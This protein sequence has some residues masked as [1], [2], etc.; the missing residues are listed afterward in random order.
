M[1]GHERTVAVQKPLCVVSALLICCST[2]YS[3]TLR[4]PLSQIPTSIISDGARTAKGSLQSA[5][6]EELGSLQNAVTGIPI[7]KIQKLSSVKSVEM[8]EATRSARD[9]QLYRVIA[10][11]V[12]RILTNKGSGSGSLIGASGEILTNFHVVEGQSEVA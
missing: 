11:S 5:Y 4:V 7:A 10:P 3:Q 9:A 1:R 12:V 6:F 2:G 8:G